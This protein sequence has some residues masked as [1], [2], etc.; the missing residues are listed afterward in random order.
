ML[1]M[2]LKYLNSQE[3]NRSLP[4]ENS[5]P[6][7]VISGPI[8]GDS[9]VHKEKSSHG[10]DNSEFVDICLRCN[11]EQNR[12]SYLYDDLPQT[13]ISPTVSQQILLL[14]VFLLLLSVSISYSS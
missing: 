14:A 10:L 5:I 6:L 8:P 9:N 11:I 13:L 12:I 7:T 3:F 4:I 2:G 1:K